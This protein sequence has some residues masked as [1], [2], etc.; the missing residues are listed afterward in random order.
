[1]FENHPTK[2]QHHHSEMKTEVSDVSRVQSTPIF[3]QR[4]KTKWRNKKR[5]YN[6]KGKA[7]SQHTMEVQRYSSYSFPTS[8]LDGVSG[9]CHAQVVL[10]PPGKDPPV[11]TLQEAGW[12]P[13]P[14]WTQR[15]QEKSFASAQESN[16][17]HPVYILCIHFILSAVKWV[18]IS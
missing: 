17:D 9:Q 15:L 7:V 4:I 12:T 14:I 3:W 18:G 6:V 8:A 13:Q 1:M 2:T 16:L 10:Y 11:P 5:I